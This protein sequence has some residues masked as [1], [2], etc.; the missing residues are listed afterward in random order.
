[1]AVAHQAETSTLSALKAQILSWYRALHAYY[2]SKSYKLRARIYFQ[3]IEHWN[4]LPQSLQPRQRKVA[5]AYFDG[6]S[7]LST[8]CGGSGAVILC[9][10]LHYIA[11]FLNHR[12]TNNETEYQGVI[13]TLSL[14]LELGVTHLHVHGD[15]QLV[16]RQLLGH[17]RVK[18]P[19]YY[20]YTTKCDNWKLGCI[21]VGPTSI[22]TTIR[23]LTSYQS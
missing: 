17:S 16:I 10:G 8:A 19:T 12:V 13:D 20:P 2:N 3:L 18:L 22:V 14:A 23:L 9:E 15:S 11:R 1:M 6:A 4:K 5:Y 7:R 21:A